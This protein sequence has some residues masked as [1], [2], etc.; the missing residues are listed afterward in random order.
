MRPEDRER[1]QIEV[2]HRVVDDCVR[3][4]R[5]APEGFLQTLVNDAIYHERRRLENGNARNKKAKSE[6]AVYQ[7]IQRRLRNASETTLRALLEELAG[8]F[9]AEIVGNFDDR[10]YRLS[11]TIIPPGLSVLLNAMNPAGMLE[12]HRPGRRLADHLKIQGEIEH[13]RGLQEKGTLVVV[14]THSSNLDSIVLGYG[15]YLIGLRPLLYGAG[16]NL[17]TNPMLSFFM[18]NL[19][20]YRVDR[21][22]TASL[23]KAVLKEYATCALEMGYD[24][25]FFPGGTRSRSGALE[26]R[27]KK[28]L[29]GTTVRAYTGNLIA[30][31]PK[32]NIY[33]VPCT[34]SYKLVLEAEA[35][36]RNY[37]EETGK[38]SF[39]IEDDEFSRPRRIL[40]FLTN[41]MGLDDEI[42]LTVSPPLDVFGNRVD[43]EGRSLDSYGR[44]VDAKSYVTTKGVPHHDTQRDT[45]YTNETAET[46][47][48]AYLNDNVVMS[49][50]L[51]ARA[52]FDLLRRRNPQQ[53]LYRLLHT[54]GDAPSF[55][56]AEVHT[57]TDGLLRAVGRAEPRAHLSDLLKQGDIQEI[58]GDALRHF[59][60]Y[61]T[62]PAATRRGD[63]IFHEY[64]NLLYYYGNRL[65]GYDLDAAI[66]C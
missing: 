38:S 19:G 46:I 57:E 10:V 21:K 44:I 34:L 55:S 58:V 25:L 65:N 62:R 15:V 13:V 16:L 45:E 63:R 64:R 12:L 28:G 30:G 14:P 5:R 33:I 6:M 23:Y 24:Q 7:D 49:T 4:A 59:A 11:T 39:I 35:L 40:N 22:K 52:L 29:M 8:R 60:I 32:P 26:Q 1:I 48:R 66:S 47:A 36:I 42:V 2:V 61:H 9:V 18:H 56:L 53:D 20:A 37:L 54:G 50:H 3:Q 17:F 41:V 27:L 51:V 43:R 31:R